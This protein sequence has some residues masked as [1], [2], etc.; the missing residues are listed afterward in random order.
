MPYTGSFSKRE[1]MR[2]RAL[3]MLTAGTFLLMASSCPTT[4]NF[5]GTP[6]NA[7]YFSSAGLNGIKV[8]DAIRVAV[9]L[10]WIMPGKDTCPVRE[11]VILKKN[12]STDS[13]FTV[14]HYNIPDTVSD[15]YDILS[16]DDIPSQGEYFKILYRIFAIDT[17]GI[18]GDTSEID[19]IRICWPPLFSCPADT[20]KQ[21]LFKWYTI[22]Y[23][24]GYYTYLYL[25]NADGDIKWTSDKPSEPSYGHE[26]LDSFY[27]YLPDSLYPLKTGNYWYGL[28]VE[29]PGENIKSLTVQEFYAP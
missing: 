2:L 27:A 21:N 13:I 26:T 28:V 24:S 1:Y 15:D 14:L 9:H 3:V 20:M 7:P 6:A 11:F 22:Q 4:E 18:S 23:M 29:I 5:H 17:F 12:S 25:W 16:A 8:S 19:S 10:K